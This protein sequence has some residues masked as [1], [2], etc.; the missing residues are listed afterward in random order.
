MRSVL[1]ALALALGAGCTSTHYDWGRYEDSVYAVT[2][3]PDGFDLG[4]EID[5]MEQQIQKASGKDRLIPPGV[6]AHVGYLHTVA[7]NADQARAH[8][9]TEKTIYPESAQFMDYLLSLLPPGT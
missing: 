8:F 3:R 2:R 7:G 5:A 4:A 1:A 9:E 6:H